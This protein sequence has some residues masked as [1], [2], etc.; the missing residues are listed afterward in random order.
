MEIIKKQKY[1]GKLYLLL[2]ASI[3][4]HYILVILFSILI[5]FEIF[6]SKDYKKILKDR[7]L[8]TVGVVLGFS[9]MTSVFYKNILGLVAIPIFLFLVV[10]RY[11]TLAV[12]V[13]LKQ[14]VLQIISK[15]SIVPFFV[16]I[17]E[18]ILKKGR[19]GYFAFFNPNYLGSVMM[20]GAIVNLY[21]FFEKRNKK[22]ISFFLLN[23][24]TLFL[25]G[26]RS[27]LIAV[28]LGIFVLLFY[29]LDK[30][31]FI[32]GTLVLLV[33]IL[34]VYLH[35]FPFLRMDTFVEYFWL[36]VE[37]VQ[38]AIVAFKRTNF[39][40]GHGNFF[41]YKF[42]NHVYP[43]SH[44]AIVEFLLS[45]GL[46]G[47]VL[48]ATVFFRYLYEILKKDRNNILKIALIVGVIFHNLTD[49]TIFW[50]QTVLLF[51]MISSYEEDNKMIKGYRK[52]KN[53]ESEN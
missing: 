19:I 27:S 29:F 20:M 42:T 8:I 50:V 34:G 6:I 41:Y 52:I 53:E 25:S 48:L 32:F 49:F 35:V 44:N 23:M 17:V 45:Y 22:N 3:F 15:F 37:I 18:F 11:Y 14:K 36:R 43:H 1:L 47:T 16:G 51:I 24:A 7:T 12:D 13:E 40:Y 4:I 28:I 21:L 39:L 31:Y 9:I 5:L 2:G 26:S 10:G 46:I 38:M 30:R 33:Y